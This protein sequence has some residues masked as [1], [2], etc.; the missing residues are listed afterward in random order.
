MR[1][2]LVISDVTIVDVESGRLHADRAVVIRGNRIV[3]IVPSER[4]A[5]SA[6]VTR[7]D[8]RG[9]YLIPGLWDMHVHSAT[10]ARAE[11]PMYLA[12][13]VTGVRN[14]HT[15]ADTALELT[16]A[17]R[18]QVASGALLGPRFVANGAIVDGMRSQPGSIPIGTPEAATRIVDSLAAGG[19]EFIKVYNVLSRDTYLA[20]IAAAKA[21]GL[22]VVGHIPATLRAEEAAAAGQR[23]VEH[24]DGMDFA[25]ST[26]EDSIRADFL[27]RPS[28]EA[29]HR[30]GDGLT[31]TWSAERCAGVVAAFARHRTWQ[32][33]T[34]AVAWAEAVGDS[35]LQDAA[36]MAVV[37]APVAARWR[38][39]AADTTHE[40]DPHGPARFRQA[41]AG[42]RML[43]AA[44]VPILAGTDAGNPF[45]IPG[46]ALHH[47]L[48]LL[49]E[50][51]LTPLAA[52]Q[53]ATVNPA[54][55][56]G[57]TDSLGTVSAGNLADLV[58]LDANPLDDI[59]NSRRIRAVIVNG[60][61]LDR[62]ALDAL[63]SPPGGATRS[64][65]P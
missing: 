17:L 61:L 8:G 32:V 43:H 48:A 64:A 23:S 51:G 46:Y 2:D 33:P 59:R 58:L 25:C 31:A 53:A 22:A 3:R 4:A 12:H 35:V 9:R 30:R 54:R 14:M 47:E 6:G 15:S 52:L 40:R 19:A 37:P 21:R 26:K 57:A 7:V 42:T 65:P 38:A 49:V 27:A 20:V 60:R 10:S 36:A 55:F 41:M 16:A 18:R 1:E 29:W 62:D 44:G 5:V 56:F 24:L 28:R 39:M 34:L 11:F 63:V 13:G 50:A 45:V